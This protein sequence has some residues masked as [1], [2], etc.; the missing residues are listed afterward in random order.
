MAQW[1]K[2]NTDIFDNDKIMTLLERK[3]GDRVFRIYIRLLCLAGTLNNSGIFELNNSTPMSIKTLAAYARVD[4]MALYKALNLLT[5]LSLISQTENGSYTIPNWEYYQN[6]DALRK[7]KDRER[8]RKERAK[9]R[10]E[11][12]NS[13]N[14]EKIND[15]FSDTENSPRTSHG[16]CVTGL[17]AEE[18]EE[19]DIDSESVLSD[20]RTIDTYT[21]VNRSLMTD[22][23][24]CDVEKYYD[25][26]D[27]KERNFIRDIGALGSGY[28]TMTD[29]QMED[30]LE[31][32]PIEMF[33][34][35]V[36]R[37]GEYLKKKGRRIN[38]CY[39]IIL[40]WYNADTA[41]DMNKKP[42][43]EQ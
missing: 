37:L 35:Y 28:V 19:K 17:L 30:L 29:R 15:E 18:E 40:K 31:R 25:D 43:Q 26:D 39:N 4:Y 32:M 1:I 2:L 13:E 9:K 16:K 22:T 34:D 42:W 12:E 41:I 14:A 21:H 23:K 11:K 20:E 36:S 38:S 27:T 3:N 7:M 24:P 6:A 8:K 10:L 33:D 5:S